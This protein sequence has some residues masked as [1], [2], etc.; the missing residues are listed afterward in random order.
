MLVAFCTDFNTL[1][2][3]IRMLTQDLQL[4]SVKSQNLTTQDY[5]VA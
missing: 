4:Y 5:L 2:M 3:Q 1:N